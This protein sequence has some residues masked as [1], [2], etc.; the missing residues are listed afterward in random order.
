ME[1]DNI[2]RSSFKGIAQATSDLA[3]ASTRPQ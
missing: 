3:R 1:K 2:P